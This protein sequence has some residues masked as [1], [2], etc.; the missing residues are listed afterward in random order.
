ME[1]R[2]NSM[3]ARFAGMRPDMGPMGERMVK[4]GLN[5]LQVLERASKNGWDFLYV[6][7][8]NPAMKFNSKLWKEARAKTQFLVVQDLFLTETAR[9]ADVVLPTLSY[10][11]KGGHFLNIEGRLQK[12]H[13]GKALPEGILNDGEIFTLIANR[14][15]ILL[16]I[17]PLFSKKLNLHMLPHERSKIMS[18]KSVKPTNGTLLATF[19]PE[20][21]D[22]GER[23]KHNPHLVQLSKEP[24]VRI[25]PKEGQ[26]RGI[27]SGDTLQLT[28]NDNTIS[29][30]VKL[31]DGVSEGTIVLPLG[32]AQVPVRELTNSLQNSFEVEVR[33]QEPGVRRDNK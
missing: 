12:I 3:G 1:G 18:S 5:A 16:T 27:Q 30:K 4:P 6:A 31:D 21:F 29:A 13:Q 33:R 24:C 15:N 9:Q 19:A 26:K 10:V 14:L 2:N 20:L 23:M 22:H 25:H 17:D 7:G 11:E 28:A 8:A 32:F